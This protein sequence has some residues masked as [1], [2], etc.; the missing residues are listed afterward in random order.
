MADK[1]YQLNFELSDG[2]TKAVRFTAPQGPEGPQGPQGEQGIQG[3]QGV[4]GETGAQ[5]PAGADGATGPAGPTGAT[6]ADGAPGKSAYDIAKEHGFEG[7]EEEWL[8][9]PVDADKIIFDADMVFT[10]AFGKYKPVDG[11]VTIPS[12]GKSWKA[13]VLDAYS[14]DKNPS[15]TDPTLTIS[16]STAKAYE[17]GTSVSPAYS[18]TFDAGSYTYGPE[19]G[20]T[21]SSWKAT[22]NVTTGTI[23]K[24]S[25]T[26]G[27]YT[28]PDGANY[29]ITLEATYTDGAIPKTALGA[30][31][32][33]G[34]I[35]GDTIS[36]TSGAITGY[37]N[38]FYGTLT[39]KS[40]TLNSA[41][42]RKLAKKSGKA[43]ANGNSFT[44][45]IPLNAMMVVFA[46][47][48]TL[49]EV[50]K[51]ADVNASNADIT[52]AFKKNYSVVSVEGA[53]GYEAINY[54]VYALFFAKANDK[55]NKY[56]VTI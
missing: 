22:N 50:T 56:T 6:G 18:G 4:Q 14:E 39:D 10:E 43:L 40:T 44:I 30:D 1:I 48:A 27:A 53:S 36:A 28:V 41:N 54:R 12:A 5:G 17:V 9:Q 37:R 26:F 32:E 15:T 47:P 13:I 8:E 49:R 51:V 35:T 21:V 31:Y 29:K 11:K 20:V 34:K 19:T 45:D 55:A 25:G 46:Y 23:S 16:S 33:A 52:D 42:I 7:T 38:T 3:P 24:Q 2:T